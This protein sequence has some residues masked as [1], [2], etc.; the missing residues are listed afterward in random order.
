MLHLIRLTYHGGNG[1]TVDLMADVSE[2][3]FNSSE[4]WQQRGFHLRTAPLCIAAY[5]PA[6]DGQ[7]HDALMVMTREEHQ[8][9]EPHDPDFAVAMK[10]RVLMCQRMPRDFEFPDKLAKVLSLH[11]SLMKWELA[12]RIHTHVIA[13]EANGVGWGLASALRDKL[14]HVVIPYTTVGST[15][16]TPYTG[17]KVSMPRLAALDNLRILMETHHLKLIPEAPGAKDLIQELNSFVW[18]RPGRPEAMQ[19]QKDDLV[20]A[21]CG[22]IWVGSRVI[23]PILKGAKPAKRRAVN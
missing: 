10:Y 19:G 4:D 15:S 7:D 17:H 3:A 11:R 2:Y 12:G 6:G 13:V 21:L 9:G 16:D 8:R 23:P 20:M 18:R 14:G 5:D 1:C 22:G